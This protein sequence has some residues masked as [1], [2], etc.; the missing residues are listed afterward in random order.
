M[1]YDMVS[2]LL[3]LKPD[4]FIRVENFICVLKYLKKYFSFKIYLY[5]ISSSGTCF[6][7]DF[8]SDSCNVVIFQE[9]DDVLHRTFYINHFIENC[10]TS[11]LAIWD[12]D[13]LIDPSQVN[14]SLERLFKFDLDFV[15]PY[16]GPF[17]DISFI[18]RDL[19]LSNSDFLVLKK[20]ES[21]YQMLF[22]PNPVGGVFFAKRESYIK[23]GMENLDF[24]GWGVEDGYRFNKIKE[25][26]LKLY[27]EFGP[28]Y[29]LTHP[30]S[31]SSRSHSEFSLFYKNLILES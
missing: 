21:T 18:V 16:T 24:Y 29:H 2:V 31:I 5:Y 26:C 3:I 11:H 1:K 23:I 6:F 28:L 8:I 19:F 4:S 10:T 7:K 22:E 17:Y 15:Y 27:R 20:Y 30:T 9:F 14:F 13:V 12:V 25:F